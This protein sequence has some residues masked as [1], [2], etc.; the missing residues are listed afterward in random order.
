MHNKTWTKHR[1]PTN[2]GRNTKQLINNNRTDSSSLKA[3]V[4]LNVFYWRQIFELDSDFIKTQNCL[5]QMKFFMRCSADYSYLDYLL[6][7]SWLLIQSRTAASES[8]LI[9]LIY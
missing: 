2:N 9:T 1:T 3:T 5:A 4:D 6:D 8:T 7:F